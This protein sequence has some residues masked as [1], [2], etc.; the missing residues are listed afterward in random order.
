MFGPLGVL[1]SARGQG[2]GRRLLLASLHAMKGIGYSYAI[3]GGPASVEFYRGVVNVMEIPDS[4]P[5]IYVD[6]LR[7]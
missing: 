7:S 6:R 4:M 1:E 5:G 3:I 2:I